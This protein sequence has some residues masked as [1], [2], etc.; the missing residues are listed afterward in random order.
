MNLLN[1]EQA[2]KKLSVEKNTLR[3]WVSNRKIPY[4]KLGRLVRF[5][6]SELNNWISS[7][8]IKQVN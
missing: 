3:D 1:I 7:K 6:E 4:V 5:N 2:S 8:T